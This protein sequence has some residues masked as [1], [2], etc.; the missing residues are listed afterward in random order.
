[1]EEIDALAEYLRLMIQFNSE[2]LSRVHGSETLLQFQ[3]RIIH[4]L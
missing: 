3:N 1:M 2:A 4:C